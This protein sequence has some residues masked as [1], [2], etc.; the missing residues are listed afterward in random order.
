MQFYE[1]YKKNETRHKSYIMLPKKAKGWGYSF[2]FN[3]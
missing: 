2:V 3:C 1:V